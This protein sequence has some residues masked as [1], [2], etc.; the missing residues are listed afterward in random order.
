MEP[1]EIKVIR[2]LYDAFN[3]GDLDGA[4]VLVSDDFQLTD[5]A[6]GQTLSGLT[7]AG[8]GSACSEQRS[9]THPPSW[10]PS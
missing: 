6:A 9:P 3:A 1:P 2:A 10:S 8:D 7:A 4:A 5:I